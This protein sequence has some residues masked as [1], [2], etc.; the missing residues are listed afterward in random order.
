MVVCGAYARLVTP[1]FYAAFQGG[2]ALA[3]IVD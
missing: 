1:S 3:L 2:F